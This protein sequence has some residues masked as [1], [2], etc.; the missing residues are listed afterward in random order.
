M[1]T[2]VQTNPLLI[3]FDSLHDTAPFSRI[4]NE[5]FLPAFCEAIDL[6]KAQFQAIGKNPEAPN[7]SH[8]ISLKRYRWPRLN[9]AQDY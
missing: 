8:S 3:D 1:T 7:F 6:A 9:T 4:K 2:T 5:H